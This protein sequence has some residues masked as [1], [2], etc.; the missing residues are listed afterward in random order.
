METVLPAALSQ[1]S[2]F[3]RGLLMSQ[4]IKTTVVR[5]RLL[6]Q[7]WLTGPMEWLATECA[8]CWPERA[9]LE[10]CM[11]QGL[12]TLPWCKHLFVL[13][14]LAEPGICLA[15]PQ[16]SY[17]QDAIIPLPRIKDVLCRFR[18]LRFMDESIYL[19]SGSLNIFNGIIGLNFSCDGSHYVPWGDF[20]SMSMDFW[21]DIGD[22]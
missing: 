5:Q 1:S 18:D 17:P 8:R 9:A 11:A 19:R 13:D 6:L 12:D 2:I 21:I 14:D 7:S 16:R 20:L 3:I 22:S 4:T 15:Y 10:R